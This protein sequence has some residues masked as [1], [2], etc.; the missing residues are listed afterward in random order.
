[1]KCFMGT[2]RAEQPRNISVG[3]VPVCFSTAEDVFHRWRRVHNQLL[4]LSFSRAIFI[5]HVKHCS[6][7]SVC[8]MFRVLGGDLELYVMNTQLGLP[9]NNWVRS[10]LPCKIKGWVAELWMF[11]TDT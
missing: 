10:L 6:R 2:G 7:I 4:H 3:V 5:L 8:L 9:A 1:M 11:S